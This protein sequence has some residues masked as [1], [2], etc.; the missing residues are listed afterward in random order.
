ME[1][2]PGLIILAIGF[3]IVGIARHRA[4]DKDG[5]LDEDRRERY[6]SERRPRQ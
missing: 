4:L 6:P 2:G 5:F 1:L 3:C